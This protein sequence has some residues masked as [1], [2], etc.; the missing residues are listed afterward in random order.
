MCLC[1]WCVCGVCV[2]VCVC[3]CVFVCVLRVRARINT[4][5]H[6]LRDPPRRNHFLLKPAAY[7]KFGLKFPRVTNLTR[8]TESGQL[9]LDRARHA[10]VIE[11]IWCVCERVCVFVCVYA[12][13]R[14][15]GG[16]VAL[17]VGWRVGRVAA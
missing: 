2:C 1:V 6:A 3:V 17:A 7:R 8:E 11:W 5:T 14:G 4:H 15:V 13:G 10:D 16:R 12:G 9:L